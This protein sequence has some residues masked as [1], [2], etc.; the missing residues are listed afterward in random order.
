MLNLNSEPARVRTG[1]K[2]CIL[3]AYKIRAVA[4]RLGSRGETP[5]QDA[6]PCR[7]GDKEKLQA[8]LVIFMLPTSFYSKRTPQ[9]TD[10]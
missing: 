3:R 5:G 6:Q 1:V 10:M 2:F 4:P 7:A 8:A 9:S